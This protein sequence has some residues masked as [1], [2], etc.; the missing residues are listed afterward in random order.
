MLVTKLSRACNRSLLPGGTA[1]GQMVRRGGSERLGAGDSIRR[2]PDL[3]SGRDALS[4][5]LGSQ[6]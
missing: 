6:F 4:A 3:G 1:L 2:H 5:L